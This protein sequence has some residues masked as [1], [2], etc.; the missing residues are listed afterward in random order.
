MFSHCVAMC[1]PYVIFWWRDILHFTK[2]MIF[3]YRFLWHIRNLSIPWCHKGMSVYTYIKH[4]YMHVWVCFEVSS[5]TFKCV[6]IWS[7]LHMVW[8]RHPIS[9]NRPPPP[10]IYQTG[11]VPLW[12]RL[13]LTITLECHFCHKLSTFLCLC[14]YLLFPL[15][16]IGLCVYLWSALQCLFSRS[17]HTVER[18]FLPSSSRVILLIFG[19]LYF[20]IHFRI[21]LSSSKRK[22]KHTDGVCDWDCIESIDCFGEKWCFYNI[23]S[24]NPWN[25]NVWGSKV[26]HDDYTW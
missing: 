7:F 23:R 1:L 6:S 20:S 3:D 24:S 9:F 5:F 18:V 17:W 8:G 19:F 22:K 25:H 16:P 26:K 11:P 2:Y 21:T 14:L 4:I 15:C 13:S 12:K 10:W